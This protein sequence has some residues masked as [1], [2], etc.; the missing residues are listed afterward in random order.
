SFKSS[1]EDCCQEVEQ[2]SGDDLLNLFSK[3]WN[4][5]EET[6]ILNDIEVEEGH[7]MNGNKFCSVLRSRKL[8]K[9]FDG[10]TSTNRGLTPSGKVNA[11]NTDYR[12]DSSLPV[13]FLFPLGI[14]LPFEH[15]LIE[16]YKIE[17]TE[18]IEDKL[19]R[20]K[21]KLN[22][23][24][25][26]LKM[27]EASNKADTIQDVV[28]SRVD[29]GYHYCSWGV[30]VI[31]KAGSKA[32]LDV[33][34]SHVLDVARK[35]LDMVMA[36]DN[37]GVWKGFY[38]SLPGCGHLNEVLRLG[39]LEVFAYK[40]HI[41]SFKRGNANG[42][43]LVDSFG[44]PYL[45]DFWDERN[46]YCEARNGLLFAPTG[47]GKT[48]LVAHIL[49]QCFW[50]NDVIFLVDVG[51]SYKKVTEVNN[52]VYVDS[53]SIENLKFNPFL[54]CYVE[55]GQYNPSKDER[56]IA[57]AMYLDFMATLICATW[58]GEGYTGPE[59]YSAIRKAIEL[60]FDYVN[61]NSIE[62]CYDTFHTYLLEEFTNDEEKFAKFIPLGKYAVIM[63]SFT[64]KGEYGYL[65]NS[66]NT[67]DIN[68]RW[69][70]FD[71]VGVI[72]KPKIKTP[73]TLLVMQ[74]FERIRT[75]W[76]GH[77]VRMFIEEAVDFL[78]GGLFSSYIAGLYRKIRKYGGQVFII[79]QSIEFLD[80]LDDLSKDSIL[81]NSE[82]KILLD[83]SKTG[84]SKEKLQRI[85]KLSDSETEL[86]DHQTPLGGSNYKL[87]FIK[88]G[89]RPGFLARHEVSEKTFMVY[90]TNAKMM[91][92]VNEIIER[93]GSLEGGIQSFI[94]EADKL[95]KGN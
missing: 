43:V 87:P 57:D 72:N 2:L 90:Q 61:E 93:S 68:N 65:L 44:R 19:K 33:L 49:D 75:R 58:K 13:S 53:S 3:C 95:E 79:T 82:I 26:L 91:K 47:G 38:S 45:F 14:G 48:F 9:H 66:K 56:G 69:V 15:M 28:D 85:L 17:E 24:I 50:N 60:Y 88:F 35:Q 73:V 84:A 80:S 32:D 36:V 22:V 39:F 37:F 52:G 34:N 21:G 7:F 5:G 40:T 41:E 81:G 55:N 54:D 76:Y 4:L 70:T 67:L 29:E 12:K 30:T 63:D 86:L 6:G 18:K 92:R 94:E 64:K 83:H 62:A 71:L 1:L 11:N 74:L 46:Q 20:E 77:N 51:G 89:S 23:F 10:F 8:P 78:Q 25:N 59:E 16:T 42:I 27:K 31:L